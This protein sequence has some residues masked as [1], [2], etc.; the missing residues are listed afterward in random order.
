[1]TTNRPSNP[2]LY[3]RRVLSRAAQRYRTLVCGVAVACL[4]ISAF[5]PVPSA[6]AQTNSPP[7]TTWAVSLVLPPKLEA[8]APA[9]LAVLGVDGRLAPDVKVD[10]GNGHT[11]VTD[12]TGRAFFTAPAAGDFLLAKASGASVAALIDP[13]R[14]ASAAAPAPVL[15]PVVPVR[16]GFPICGAGLRGDSDGNRVWINNQPALVLAASPECLVILPGPYTEVGPATVSVN[17]P[18]V[19]WNVTTTVVS[20]EFDPPNPPLLPGKKGQLVVRARGTTLKLRVAVENRTPGILIFRRG[21][22]QEAVTSG[23]DPDAAALEVQ[24]I[25]SGDFSFRARLLAVADPVAA[26]RYLA[27]AASL[28]PSDI[29]REV[30]DLAHRLSRHP[31]DAEVVRREVNAILVRTIPSDFRTLLAA[32]LSSL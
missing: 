26:Q 3:Y 29:A 17:A 6:P 8:G 25:S 16:D 30:A 27:A 18:G 12:R 4:S 5:L 28:A 19:N 1:M 24:A 14:P 22:V 2:C 11:V 15:P 10:L 32:A 21:D 9:T 23:G 31:R 20:L 13:P 7:L